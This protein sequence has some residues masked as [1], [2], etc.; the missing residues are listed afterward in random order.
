MTCIIGL[1]E[2]NKVYLGGDSAAAGDW[3]L[4][5]SNT[6]KVFRVGPFLIGYTTS[7]RMGQIL[8]YQVDFPEAPIYDE[9]YMVTKFIEA[10]RL[11]FKELGYSMIQN[12]QE[13]GGEFIVGVQGVIYTIE[14]DFQVNH[15]RDHFDAVGIGYPF[16]LGAMRALE[17]I[18]PVD[19][20]MK[21]LEITA[22]FAK[23]VLEP[24]TVLEG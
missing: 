14:G 8:Q 4:R 10:V 24:F 13:S 19:R 17:N 5:V 6:K 2:N 7:F 21:S 9:K 11:K 15:Y 20:I 23:G 22:Q 18:S 1:A 12:N 16:A 3:S